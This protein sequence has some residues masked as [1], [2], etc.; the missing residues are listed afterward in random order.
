MASGRAS[1]QCSR[2]RQHVLALPVKAA[3]QWQRGSRAA[4]KP[5]VS[6]DARVDAGAWRGLGLSRGTRRRCGCQG[7]VM[8]DAT[9]RVHCDVYMIPCFLGA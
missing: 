5:D 1:V 6:G 9:I 4:G 3:V 8:N 2:Q 7:F